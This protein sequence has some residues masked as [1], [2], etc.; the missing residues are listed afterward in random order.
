MVPVTRG[1]K[2]TIIV[3]ISVEFQSVNSVC[4]DGTLVYSNKDF[5]GQLVV[6]PRDAMFAT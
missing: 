2:T 5:R 4:T 3:E 1:K 6:P